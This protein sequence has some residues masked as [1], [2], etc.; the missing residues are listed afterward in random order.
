MTVD[1]R[2][3]F[4][5]DESLRR[6]A[7]IHFAELTTYARAKAIAELSLRYQTCSWPRDRRIGA[8][9]LRYLGTP[10]EQLWVAFKSEAKMPVS[11]RRLRTI[12]AN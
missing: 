9:P 1:R 11:E 5:R 2:A 10:K 12:L 4:V 6:L 7:G 8:V 3:S